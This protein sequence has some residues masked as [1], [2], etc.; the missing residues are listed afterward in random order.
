VLGSK[1]GNLRTELMSSPAEMRFKNLTDV[2]TRRYAKRVENDLDGSA[3][4][5]YGMSSSGRM[6]AITPLLP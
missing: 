3:I 6:R 4:G 1:C 2:H 5:R